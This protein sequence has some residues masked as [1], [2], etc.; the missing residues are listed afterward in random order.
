MVVSPQH[1]AEV[2]HRYLLGVPPAAK[3]VDLY[4]RYRS[5]TLWTPTAQELRAWRL[6]L[7][8]PFLMGCFDAYLALV[9]PFSAYRQHIYAMLAIAESLPHHADQFLPKDYALADGLK[10]VRSG[11]TSLAKA[12][13]GGVC[14]NL[15]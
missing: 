8:S 14:W 5:V 12:I 6:A 15:L 9:R 4:V 3:A 2:L 11:V 7:R 10:V 13:I 1:E